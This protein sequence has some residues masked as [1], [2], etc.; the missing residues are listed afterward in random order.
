MPA[1]AAG[2]TGTSPP[3]GRAAPV[4]RYPARCA[5]P[6]ACPGPSVDI[7]GPSAKLLGE[8]AMASLPAMP[9]ARDPA[10]DPAPPPPGAAAAARGGVGPEPA[11]SSLR[12]FTGPDE[13]PD[14]WFPGLARACSAGCSSTRARPSWDTGASASPAAAQGALPSLA[15]AAASAARFASVRGCGRRGLDGKPVAPISPPA[16]PDPPAAPSLEDA[17]PLDDAK[18]PPAVA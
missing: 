10:P 9:A 7:A 5:A 17:A 14:R 11:S 15:R 16:W 1:P 6:T 12:P 18:E 4:D 13:S 2:R 3:F 8:A